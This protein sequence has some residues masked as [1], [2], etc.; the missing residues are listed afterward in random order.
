L[1]RIGNVATP[2]ACGGIYIAASLA[3]LS[4][5][6]GQSLRALMCWIQRSRSS[7]R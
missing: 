3:F 2:L 6:E 5:L 1:G 4:I 7:E